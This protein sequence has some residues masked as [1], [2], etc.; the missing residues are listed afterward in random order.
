[1]STPG[2]REAEVIALMKAHDINFSGMGP[3]GY[4]LSLCDGK[5]FTTVSDYMSDATLDGVTAF[6]ATVDWDDVKRFYGR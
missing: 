1:M 5:Y 3:N 4:Y 6:I 2:D